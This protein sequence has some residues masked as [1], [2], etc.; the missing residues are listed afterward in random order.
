MDD[1]IGKIKERATDLSVED[2]DF[3]EDTLSAY[4]GYGFNKAHATSYGLLA[5]IT[6]WF[7]V[8][9]P[10][11]FWTAMLDA[12]AGEPQEAEYLKAARDAGIT[13]RSPH[14]N[15]SAVSFTADVPNKAIRKGLLS[16]S[17]IGQKA[18]AEIAAHAPYTE[19]SQFAERV[20]ARVVTGAKALRSGHSPAACGGV[21]AILA[22]TGALEGIP[23]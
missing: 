8:H 17:G 19:L 7:S 11:E 9:H 3:I 1:L 14:I 13:I 12:Y 10:V 21:V 22:S 15:K 18:A 23:A 6:T 4:A 20:N 2:L 5:Y 16:I